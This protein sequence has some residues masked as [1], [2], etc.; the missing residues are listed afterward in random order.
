MLDYCNNVIN[1]EPLDK[2]FKTFGWKAKVVKDGH[3][4][5]ELYYSLK[6]IKEDDEKSP[7]VLIAYTI[8][9]KGVPQLEKDVRCHVRMLYEHEI[10]KI[11]KQLS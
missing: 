6:E 9:G 4:I 5:E 8:K 2:K 1:L 3:N 10:D 7:K 11:I